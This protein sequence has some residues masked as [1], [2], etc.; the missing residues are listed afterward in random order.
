MVKKED[1]LRRLAELGFPMF[2]SQIAEDA[3]LTLADVVRS[4]ELRLWEGFPVMLA[5]SALRGL[6]DRDK[7][8]GYLKL[9]SDRARFEQLLAMSL[10]LYR[11]TGLRFSWA[12]RLQGSL[13]PKGTKKFEA[14]LSALKKDATFKMDGSEMSASRLK[15]TF[16]NY[17]SHGGQKL[18]D[19]LA[20]KDELGTEY[21]LSQ[22][23]SPKQKELFL[24]KLQG[25]KFTKTE[26]EY[27]SRA[28]KKKVLALANTE[29]H[30][31]ARKL[32]EQG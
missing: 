26:R 10:A 21:A 14:F 28:V 6:L 13:G 9:S 7:V 11:A 15:N 1:L 8:S 30:R 23:F 29:L 32:L 12:D 31:M 22:L 18:N 19:L 20:E 2:E 27:F 25:S 3:N 4:H 24:K 5:N 17:F 16:N